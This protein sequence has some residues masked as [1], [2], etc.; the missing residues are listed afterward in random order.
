MLLTARCGALALGYAQCDAEA[1]AANRAIMFMRNANNKRDAARTRT[2]SFILQRSY[3]KGS[4]LFVSISS[5]CGMICEARRKAARR[6]SL[7]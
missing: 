6:F 4:N 7:N 1:V 3:K 2:D 5:V